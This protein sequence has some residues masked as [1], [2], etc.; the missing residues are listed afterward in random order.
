MRR[1]LRLALGSLAVGMLVLGCAS[2]VDRLA[3]PQAT[4]SSQ[5]GPPKVIGLPIGLPIRLPIRLPSLFG[6]SPSPQYFV[7]QGNGGPYSGS[8]V[9]GALGGQVTFGPHTLI[10][11]PLAL[12]KP[13]TITA[14]TLPGDT[15][16]VA[17]QPQGL[18]FLLPATLELSYGQCQNQPDKP[19][20]VVYVS[21]DLQWL[22]QLI[23][24]IDLLGQKEVTGSISHFSVYAAAE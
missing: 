18:T 11:P 14:R 17:L 21:D 6:Q 2:D 19:L 15:I 20:S 22:L 16:A 9:I 10:V 3:G 7:C 13:T 23:N 24:S 4:V 8:A 5:W 1:L 12:L